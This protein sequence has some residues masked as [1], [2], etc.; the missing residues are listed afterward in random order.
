VSRLRRDRPR[1]SRA[2]RTTGLRGRR[3]RARPSDGQ[4]RPLRR[5]DARRSRRLRRCMRA[6]PHR[7]APRFCNRRSLGG[8]RDHDRCRRRRRRRLRPRHRFRRRRLARRRQLGKRRQKEER[9]EV[10]LRVGGPAHSKVHVWD[11]LLGHPARAHRANRVTLGE[12]RPARDR[13]GAKME[14]RDGVAVGRPDRDRPPAGRHGPRE[15]D[16][17]AHRRAHRDTGPGAD[18]DPPV[19]TARVW[20]G[21]E[22]E[23]LQN[24]P[25]YRPGPPLRRCGRD[26][27]RR[28]GAA[29]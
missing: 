21:A 19:Q 16:D 29:G 10:P 1:G 11:G 18:V 9:V 28:R 23:R 12:S 8:R 4:R 26:E 25:L 2:Q 5:E 27:R 24:R 3:R 14:Q 17:P 13:H 20:I 6:Q 22:A 15:R 7:R